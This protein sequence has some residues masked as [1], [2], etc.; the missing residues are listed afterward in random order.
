MVIKGGASIF[1][2]WTA[3]LNANMCD[4]KGYDVFVENPCDQ[5]KRIHV[6][7]KAL[8]YLPFIRS[9]PKFYFLITPILMNLLFIFTVISSLFI[10][11]DKNRFF[12]L[13]FFIISIPVLLVVER[14]NIDLAIFITMYILAKNNNII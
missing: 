12:L 10:Y 9:F 7:G 8:L 4:E 13:S 14:S 5:W 3:I 6:Y 2:D 11:E 1:T